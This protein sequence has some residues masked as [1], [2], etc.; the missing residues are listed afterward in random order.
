MFF[1]ATVC[2]CNVT[3]D[4]AS[5]IDWFTKYTKDASLWMC[6]FSKI[7]IENCVIDSFQAALAKERDEESSSRGGLEKEVENLKEKLDEM[8]AHALAR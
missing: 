7:Y 5:N 2:S 1:F 4:I 8:E 3:T 6:V